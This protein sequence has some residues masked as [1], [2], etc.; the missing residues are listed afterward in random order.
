MALN[1]ALATATEAPCSFKA[2]PEYGGQ[3]NEV[4]WTV[5]LKA[6][7]LKDKIKIIFI[8]L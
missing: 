5:S 4:R 3:V 1:A 8:T 7:T 2:F 6:G